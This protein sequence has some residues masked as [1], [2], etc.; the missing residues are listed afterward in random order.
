MEIEN[1]KGEYVDQKDGS[2]KHSNFRA[3]KMPDLACCI[4][5]VAFLCLMI[6]IAVMSVASGNA[7]RLIAPTDYV[8]NLCGYELADATSLSKSGSTF[9][10]PD[11][12][13]TDF[14]NVFYPRLE[15]DILESGLLT[16]ASLTPEALAKI[17][18]FGVCVENCPKYEVTVV[19]GFNVTQLNEDT[20]IYVCAYPEQRALD[21]VTTFKNAKT[22]WTTT[23][24]KKADGTFA[25]A[26]CATARRARTNYLTKCTKAANSLT[27][28]IALQTDTSLERPCQDNDFDFI[29]NCFLVPTTYADP[30]FGYCFPSSVPK[31][32]IKTCSFPE[33][34]AWNDTRCQAVAVQESHV[35]IKTPS[36][37]AG[38]E[39]PLYVTFGSYAD[40]LRRMIG[41]MYTLRSMIGLMSTVVPFAL[42][43]IIVILVGRFVDCV[44]YLCIILG[45][46]MQFIISIYLLYKGDVITN[47]MA[48][49]VVGTAI[50]SNATA[51]L[52]TYMTE[53]PS[54]EK[55]QY[56]IA[57]FVMLTIFAICLCLVI[58][59][60][61]SIKIAC[62][63]IEEGAKC[64]TAQLSM[65]IY[66]FFGV[67]WI[68]GLAFYW[69]VIAMYIYTMRGDPLANTAAALDKATQFGSSASNM[70][71]NESSYFSN[72]SIPNSTVINYG[73]Y[74]LKDVFLWTHIFG[75]LWIL[76]VIHYFGVC[77]L[78]DCTITYLSGDEHARA[79]VILW[80][81]IKT[82][83]YHMGS[84]AMG[85][86][87]LAV[88]EFIRV[89]FYVLTYSYT[90][91]KT[92]NYLVMAIVCVID[93]CLRCIEK[94]IQYCSE[95]A[96]MLCMLKDYGFCSAAVETFKLVMSAENLWVFMLCGFVVKVVLLCA[97]LFCTFTAGFV[98]YYIVDTADQY[99][100]L[101]TGTNCTPVQNKM[102]PAVLVMIIAFFVSSS[103][104]SVYHYSIDTI[105]T[106][107]LYG[108]K[109]GMGFENEALEELAGEHRD[110]YKGLS[111][112]EPLTES[113]GEEN[114]A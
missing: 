94:C 86:F 109:T 40:T 57:G 100:A 56:A 23:C 16:T 39:N 105:L 92:K 20:M 102:L 79:P 73:D 107:Y 3:S 80:S 93:C 59:C 113:D 54:D 61:K 34:V 1:S 47:E 65:T 22:H 89:V 110:K 77:V 38:G 72:F 62:V 63:V 11:G 95:K 45:L 101:C 97:K 106:T 52:P 99:S 14:K 98:F 70:T 2:T 42:A 90:K 75:G 13:I 71:G 25:S 84:V 27:D 41:D 114:Q 17:N 26:D 68:I 5:F 108:K 6:V 53:T 96:F 10:T 7:L 49:S 33:N 31:T 4:A 24:E 46:L 21:N 104:L 37:A 50:V 78:A 32:I 67:L 87:L 91:G 36:E 12:K 81:S 28:Y 111:R 60:R 85:A 30:V 88:V 9:N 103:Y 76:N 83:C 74:A 8:G 48:A 112:G 55:T 82:F 66:P 51:A 15:K 19:N 44:V 69:I 43:A 29:N 58:A 35:V 18:L 64:V